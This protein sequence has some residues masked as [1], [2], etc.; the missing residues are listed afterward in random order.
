[1]RSAVFLASWS[2]C[3]SVL[4]LASPLQRT[5]ETGKPHVGR[6]SEAQSAEPRR[7]KEWRNALHFSPL[8]QQFSRLPPSAHLQPLLPPREC[9]RRPPPHPPQPFL[10]HLSDLLCPHLH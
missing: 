1:M 8:R 6:I 9:F 10:H 7:R 4:R 3:S 2:I 5:P